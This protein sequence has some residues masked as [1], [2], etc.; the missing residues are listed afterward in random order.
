MEWRDAEFEW[1]NEEILMSPL[2]DGYTYYFRI[3]PS[4]LA[5]NTCPRE[6][7]EYKVFIGSNETEKLSLPVIPLK[8]IM[9]GK[10]RNIEITAD[11]NGDGIFEKTLEEYTGI[12]LRAMKANQYWVDYSAGEI[13]FGDG[14]DG[15]M[16]PKN[17]SLNLIFNAYDLVTTIDLK[18][19]EPIVQ[20]DYL[21]EDRNNVTITWEK[22]T[23]ATGFI[24]ETKKNFSMPWIS[25]AT[26]DSPTSSELSYKAINLSSGFHYYRIV[27]IDRMGYTNPN[28]IDEHIRVIIEA[29]VNTVIEAEPKETENL[30]LYGAIAV[31][32]GS[33]ALYGA[34]RLLKTNEE[35]EIISEPV[36]IPVENLP[37]E[38][39]NIIESEEIETFSVV[40]GSQF[41]RQLM[42]I[43]KQ[44]CMKEFEV[45]SEEEDDDVPSL[46]N[47]RRFTLD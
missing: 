12:D 37:D 33:V 47:Y 42:Y 13:V 11:E 19:P 4:D 31:I 36:L 46:W 1:Q 38:E 20:I 40:P 16:P 6:P 17:S 18:P 21:I 30:Y 9:I 10:I 15:Y 44:G 2:I 26:I 43:C 34:S 7:Y 5:G 22:P 27:S 41:S 25:L 3:N 14:Q 28:M 32:L 29:E 39:N 23:D 24:V 45:T 35:S 8:P